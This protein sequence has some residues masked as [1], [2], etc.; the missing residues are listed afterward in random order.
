MYIGAYIDD[1]ILAGRTEN[2]FKRLLKA[3]Q[4]SMT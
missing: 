3:Y 4:R 1:I 2:N